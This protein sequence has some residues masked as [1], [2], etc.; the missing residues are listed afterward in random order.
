M[1]KLRLRHLLQEVDNWIQN[2]D[3]KINFGATTASVRALNYARNDINKFLFDVID[4]VSEG[5]SVDAVNKIEDK[6]LVSFERQTQKSVSVIVLPANIESRRIIEAFVKWRSLGSQSWNFPG[7]SDCLYV[8]QRWTDS[9]KNKIISEVLNYSGKKVDYLSYAMAAEY[10]RLILNGYCRNFQSPT[11]FTPEMLLQ[12]NPVD[13]GVN[14]HTKF[15]NDLKSIANSSD[16]QTNRRCVLQYFNLVQGTAKESTNYEIDYISF[17]KAARRV[18][19]NGLK[20]NDE[21]LQLDDPIPKRKR[22]SEHLKKILDRVDRVVE[23]EK[24]SIQ[25]C[26]SQ[27]STMIET[28]EIDEESIK[29]LLDGIKKFYEQA[30]N[31]HVSIAMHVDNS[32][33]SSCKKNAVSIA[34]AVKTAKQVLSIEDS[35]ECLIKLSRDPLYTISPFFSLLEMTNT[36]M[37][38]ANAEIENRMQNVSNIGG[39]QIDEYSAEKKM[40]SECKTTLERLG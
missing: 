35:I 25:N 8:V 19:G 27:L 29:D 32:L 11:N 9:I 31:T 24:E 21:S 30:K 10:Y 17:C 37:T 5:V 2:K 1:R 39:V 28:D 26:I 15:W 4:W 33:I 18:I 3:Y 14:G 6:K 7:S 34:N 20:Y 22:V 23:A 38:K 40:I 12:A 16:G 36:D 13:D